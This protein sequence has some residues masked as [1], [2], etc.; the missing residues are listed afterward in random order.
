MDEMNIISS[1]VTGFVGNG[2]SC[3]LQT[4]PSWPR[5]AKGRSVGGGGVR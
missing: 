5:E 2:M 3:R 1:R 4:G